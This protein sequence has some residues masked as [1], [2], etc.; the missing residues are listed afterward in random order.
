M[1]DP[2][3]QKVYTH[4]HHA[5][6]LSSH[7]WRTAANSAPH[8]LPHLNSSLIVLDVGCGPGTITAD[9]AKLTKHVTAIETN[10]SILAK[11][12]DHAVAKGVSNI[13]FEIGDVHELKYPDN[14]FDV[15]HAHQVLQHVSDPVRALQ[16]MRRVT[17]P[18][19]IVAIR[20]VDFAGTVWYPA[21]D[22]LPEWLA[23]YSRV[24]RAN[25][26]E[27]NAGRRLHAWAR[28][29]GFAPEKIIKGSSTWTYST[30]DEVAWWSK[31]WAERT[32]ASD[33][34]KTALA[35][36]VATQEEL[37]SAS[38]AWTAWGQS[39]DPYM[40]LIHGEMLARV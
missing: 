25:G 36:G 38:R 24:A 8:L 37:E 17:K 32:L 12:A 19:G 33:F 4:G 1:V 21:I 13:S 34:A 39:E 31:L 22:G 15:V 10:E 35:K 40:A 30:Q 14:T 5:S 23:L 6:V 9:I 20:E 11:A 29:A 16:E 18:D 2:A 3:S 28:A 27:P 7:S 26:G